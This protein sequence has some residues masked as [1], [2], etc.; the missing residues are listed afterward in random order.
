M[1][2]FR[3]EDTSYK[4]FS[5]ERSDQ[6]LSRYGSL[7]M[8]REVFF[9]KQISQKTRE[10]GRGIM[11]MHDS[12]AARRVAVRGANSSTVTCT[13]KI[14]NKIKVLVKMFKI[15]YNNVTGQPKRGM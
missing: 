8:F 2:L 3:R 4:M 1:L 13:V 9:C 6:Q 14:Y 12:C 10:S 15:C 5:G 7:A 11:R